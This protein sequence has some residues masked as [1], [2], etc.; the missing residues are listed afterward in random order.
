MST[1]DAPVSLDDDRSRS[2]ASTGATRVLLCV[3][4]DAFNAPDADA[5]TGVRGSGS[6]ESVARSSSLKVDAWSRPVSSMKWLLCF[7]MLG[8]KAYFSG[9]VGYVSDAKT[10]EKVEDMAT[11]GLAY[12][13]AIQ[14]SDIVAVKRSVEKRSSILNVWYWSHLVNQQQLKRSE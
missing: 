5:S 11:F 2:E 8:W 10:R 12:G 3:G 4:K 1:A 14:G 6:G 13:Y 9:E 7:V